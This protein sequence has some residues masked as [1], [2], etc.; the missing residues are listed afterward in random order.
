MEKPFYSLRVGQP[1]PF[2]VEVPS[3]G[4]AAKFVV[5]AAAPVLAVAVDKLTEADLLA[6]A[7]GRL[8][9][10]LERERTSAFLIWRFVDPSGLIITCDTPLHVGLEPYA[11]FPNL[12]PVGLARDEARTVA[13]VAQDE[14]TLIRLIRLAALPRRVFVH[15]D[16]L[17]DQQLAERRRP[18]LEARHDADKERYYAR[19]GSV[20]QAFARAS[21]KASVL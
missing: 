15:L 7:T 3:G 5:D 4:L 17:L 1:S 10:A 14:T 21:V 18:D 12:S 8:T 13:I 6:L 2:Q 19:T 11:I 20:T 16:H 9:V